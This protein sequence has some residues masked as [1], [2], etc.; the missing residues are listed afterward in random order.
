[1][2]FPLPFEPGIA[3][4]KSAGTLFVSGATALYSIDVS[5]GVVTTLPTPTNGNSWDITVTQCAGEATPEVSG[6]ASGRLEAWARSS[7][8]HVWSYSS[9]CTPER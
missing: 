5:T 7:T 8:A 2:G 4:R 1:M 6:G 3:L 9:I